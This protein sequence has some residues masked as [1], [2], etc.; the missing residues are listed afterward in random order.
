MESSL[1]PHMGFALRDLSTFSRS[2]IW[3]LRP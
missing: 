2:S 3:A 1:S